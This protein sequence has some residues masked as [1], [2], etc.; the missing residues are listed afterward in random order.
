MNDASKTQ[1]IAKLG[2]GKIIGEMSLLTGQ[3]RTADAISLT[4][5]SLFMI[6]RETLLPIIKEHPQVADLLATYISERATDLE[7][8]RTKNDNPIETQKKIKLMTL[9]NIKHFFG[10]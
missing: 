6:K 3:N 2:A 9:K 7:L 8:Q 1:E 10:I 4:D 5:C